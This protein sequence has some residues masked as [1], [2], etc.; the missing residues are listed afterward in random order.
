MF[1]GPIFGVNNLLRSENFDEL[2]F[3]FVGPLVNRTVV[4]SDPKLYATF[5]LVDFTFAR[6]SSEWKRCKSWTIGS[7]PCYKIEAADGEKRTEPKYYKPNWSFSGFGLGLVW[8]NNNGI[9]QLRLPVVGRRIVNNLWLTTGV[10][11]MPFAKENHFGFTIGV[12][13]SVLPRP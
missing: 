6:G 13:S 10:G 5:P 12:Q 2:L 1:S 9:L 8:G 7:A 4:E 3:L 11:I